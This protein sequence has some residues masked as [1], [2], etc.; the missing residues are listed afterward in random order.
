[1]GSAF[2]VWRRG[3]M[4]DG[5][6]KL[7]GLVGLE[8]DY[9]ID[10]GVSRSDGWPS[11][12]SASMDPEFPKDIGLADSLPGTGFV[13]LSAAAKAFLEQKQVR[14]IEYL[15]IKIINHK[16][17]AMIEPYFVLNPLEIVD[18][19]D[20]DASG[21]RLSPMN[22]TMIKSCKQLVLHE[23]KVPAEARV[24]RTAFW[25]GRI[26]IRRDLAEEMN[27]AGLTGMTFL[28]P[29]TYTGLI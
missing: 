23:E 4:K 21:V 20:K 10:D 17:R 16:G 7:N 1:M 29:Q 18:C 14:N 22:K 11:D 5:I 25:S 13:L 27:A 26:L 2:L 15:P 24:F 9:E 8:D 3:A 28:E 12:V 19:I 6:C